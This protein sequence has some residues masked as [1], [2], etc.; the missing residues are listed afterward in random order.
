MYRAWWTTESH[1]S[2]D[3]CEPSVCAEGN[4]SGVL[5]EFVTNG[6]QW[7]CCTECWYL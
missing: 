2:R 4:W 1:G 7:V 6:V 3:H 5:C